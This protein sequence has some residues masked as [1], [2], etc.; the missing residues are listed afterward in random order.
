MLEKDINYVNQKE[1]ELEN[2]E[3]SLTYMSLIHE[4]GY[5]P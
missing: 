1:R 5:M 2:N 4:K 3:L